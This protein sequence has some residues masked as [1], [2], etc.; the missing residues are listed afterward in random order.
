MSVTF[1]AGTESG[2]GLGT[3]LLQRASAPLSGITCGI[4]GAFATVTGGTN[5]T[6]PLVDTVTAGKME[7]LAAGV[8]LRPLGDAHHADVVQAEIG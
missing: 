8:P 6:S 7:V 4:Y 5:P 1:A 2:S 3:A